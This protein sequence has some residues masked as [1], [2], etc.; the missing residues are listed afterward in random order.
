MAST[1]IP[2][3]WR[4]P[5]DRPA[6]ILIVRLSA[7]GDVIHALP[8]VAALRQALPAAT[9]D[10][11]VEDRAA[12]IVQARPE[13][14]RAIV[15]PRRELRG[16]ARRPLALMSRAASFRRELATGDYDVSIDLQGNLKSGVV[17]R[18]SGARL[19]VGAD[20]RASREASHL[21]AQRHARPPT[22]IRHRVERNLAI[23]SA[24]LG[25]TLDWVDPGLPATPDAAD[26]AIRLLG[27]AGLP[28]RGYVLLHPGTSAFGSFKRW[29]AARFADLA[30]RLRTEGHAV[31]VSASAAER[32]LAARIVERTRGRDVPIVITPDLATLGEVIRRASLFVAADTGPLHFAALAGTPLIGLFG[33]KDAA[34]YGPYGRRRDGTPGPLDV[35]VRE[36][37]ACRPCPFRR[38]ANPICMRGLDAEPVTQLAIQHLA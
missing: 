17:L 6:R 12:P 31:A 18:L 13:I 15:F 3:L 20:R 33:P 32:A 19:R 21:F 16:L 38:C 2:P 24:V 34:V 28:E 4:P 11:V 27:E 22:T 29:P 5:T 25:R 30:D 9:I 36:D 7:L 37:V 10:W 23:V 26:R 14:D 35:V 8:A 1:S